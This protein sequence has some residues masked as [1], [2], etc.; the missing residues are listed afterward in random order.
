[1]LSFENPI[2]KLVL[3]GSENLSVSIILTTSVL[4]QNINVAELLVSDIT[5][6]SPGQSNNV[7]GLGGLYLVM[8]RAKFVGVTLDL[9]PLQSVSIGECDMIDSTIAVAYTIEYSTEI[10]ISDTSLSRGEIIFVYTVSSIILEGLFYTFETAYLINTSPSTTLNVNNCSISNISDTAIFHEGAIDGEAKMIIRDTRFDSIGYVVILGDFSEMSMENC[11]LSRSTYGILAYNSKEISITHSRISTRRSGL[12][13]LGVTNVSVADSYFTEN[14]EAIGSVGSGLTVRNTVLQNNTFGIVI[15]TVLIPGG[16]AVENSTL[17]FENCLFKSNVLIG[18]AIVNTPQR[19]V[20]QNC[21]FYENRGTPLYVYQSEVELRGETTFRDNTAERGGGLALFNSTVIFGSESNTNFINNIATEFGG[22][23]YVA[24]LPPILPEILIAIESVNNERVQMILSS[25]QILERSCF[26]QANNIASVT[27]IANKALQGGTDIYGAQLYGDTCLITDNQIFSFNESIPNTS[28]TSS[29]PTRVCFCDDNMIPQCE[30][31]KYLVLNMTKYPG[32]SI[33]VPVILAG[34]YFGQVAGPLYT[35]VLGRDYNEVIEEDQ[36]VQAVGTSNCT[37]LTF[38]ISSPTGTNDNS[39]F[40]TLDHQD[41]YTQTSN[42]E[43][44]YA[45]VL[46]INSD[47]CFEAEKPPCTAFLNTP[48]Y[49]HVTLEA[50]PLG[51]ELNETTRKCDCDRTIDDIRKN[52]DLITLT[53]VLENQ[54]GYISIEGTLWM[55]VD[56]RVNNTNVYNWQRNC[57]NGYCIPSRIPVNLRFPDNQCSSNR[58]GVLCGGCQPGYSLH[59]GGNGCMK[60]DNSYLA[61]LVVFALLGILLVALIKLL[62]LTVTSG[63]ISGLIF[64]ANVVWK[65]N[66]LLFP[67]QSAEYYVTVPIAWINLDFGIETC[68]SASLDQLTKTGIQFVFPVYIWCIAGLIIFVSHYSTRATRLFGSNSVPVLATLFL[69][70]YGKVFKNIIDVFYSAD[71]TDSNGLTHKVWALD[72]NVYFGQ[73]P[74][75]IILILV[76]LLFSVLF[77]IPFT[78]MLLLEPFLRVKSNARLL[79]WINTLKPFFESYYGPFKDKKQYQVWTGILLISRVVILIVFASLTG[80]TPNANMLVMTVTAAVLSMYSA[81]T[82]L[83]YKN[84]F[85][86]VLEMLYL[87]NLIILGGAFLFCRTFQDIE[88]SN[89]Q[90]NIVSATS[91]CIALVQF[92][93]TLVFHIVK[94]IRSI[95]K[96]K[97]WLK[98]VSPIDNIRIRYSKKRGE[99]DIA[100]TNR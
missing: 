69:L 75:H 35:N 60:C 38:N 27:F 61:L 76:A 57:P 52:F 94:Q 26:Y 45:R 18:I 96:F 21:T 55:G 77:I 32:D 90:V 85:F 9:F 14:E 40:L 70:S 44:I 50:C 99:V 54:A 33:K 71:I 65:N 59:L 19:A 49:I 4:L 73:T 24:S 97:T 13:V 81:L 12:T 80:Y 5:M 43:E 58:S 31:R 46:A 98:T 62:D 78:L 51:F 67:V 74:G 86:S 56:T 93:V 2:N 89:S 83:L 22:A 11:N 3:C 39:I 16:A 66:E 72:G 48:V 91:V 23:I 88:Y 37:T 1:M 82:S 79:R 63:T 87:L 84:L 68:F 92:A 8:Y 36:H 100:K 29:D 6:T 41:R 10:N 53:C 42:E 20:V 64:Y 34:Y 30:N 25:D 15:T 95:T 17:L 47:R 28:R 7:L